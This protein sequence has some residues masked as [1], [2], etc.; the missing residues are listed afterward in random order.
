MTE[1]ASGPADQNPYEVAQV[2]GMNPFS[3]PARPR[4]PGPIAIFFSVVLGLTVA[5]VT[6]CVTFLFTFPG[7][8]STQ[9]LN[10]EGGIVIVV[11]VSALTAIVAFVFTVWGLL[12]MG[13]LFRS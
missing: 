5:A 9:S 11:L 13:K 8:R 6:L 10:D 3:E 2:G 7:V 1:D 4:P 12:K